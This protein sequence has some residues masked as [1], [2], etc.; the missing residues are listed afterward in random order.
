MATTTKTNTGA[1]VPTFP[2]SKIAAALRDELI[3]SVREIAR[4]RGDA[5][6][7]SNSDLIVAQ[8]E[9]DSLTVVEILVVLDGLLPFE[10]GESAVKA[11]GYTSIK[12]AVD[13]VVARVERE[14]NKYHSGSKS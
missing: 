14:W 9:I 6:P 8:L 3:I 2:A 11:G 5:I 12:E 4:R 13:D 1:T 10:V 7:S